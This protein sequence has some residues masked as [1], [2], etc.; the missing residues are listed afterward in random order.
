MVRT[1]A[2]SRRGH[3]R[4]VGRTKALSER[5]GYG[6]A[7]RWTSCRRFRNNASRSSTPRRAS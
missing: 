2:R 3:V 7:S 6:A 4:L 1:G 5:S